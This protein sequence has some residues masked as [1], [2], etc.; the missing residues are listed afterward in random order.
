MNYAQL[1]INP[2]PYHQKRP[3]YMPDLL[4]NL[5]SNRSIFWSWGVEGMVKIANNSEDFGLMFHVQGAKF[6]GWV[7]IS[8]NG[9]D[10]FDVE[11]FTNKHEKVEEKTDIDCFSLVNVIDE[12]IEKQANYA[13]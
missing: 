7:V 9:M 12:H 1:V 8:L 10:Y 3:I 5:Q 4:A 6:K 2:K 13:F 11:F